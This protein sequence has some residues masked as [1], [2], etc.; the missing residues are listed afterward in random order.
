MWETWETLLIRRKKTIKKKQKK[1]ITN[2]DI[3]YSMSQECQNLANKFKFIE[4]LWDDQIE[5]YRK[6]RI[7]WETLQS[8]IDRLL[9]RIHTDFLDQAAEHECPEAAYIQRKAA[10]YSKE[11]SRLKKIEKNLEEKSQGKY[12]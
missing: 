11:Y 3:S 9:Y 12:R 10:F 6:L 4:M 7:N 8:G 2:R 1:E 5:Q